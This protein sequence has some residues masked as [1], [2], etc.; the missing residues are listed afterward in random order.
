MQAKRWIVERTLAWI[1]INRKLATDFEA[2][3]ATVQTLI[4]I[5]MIK[6]MARRMA[7][8]IQF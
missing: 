1:T 3:A 8:Y 5:A 4:Q 6:L 7:R 2:F